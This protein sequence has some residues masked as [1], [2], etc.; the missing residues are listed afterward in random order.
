MG[1]EVVPAPD[2]F[3]FS[4]SYTLYNS[5]PFTHTGV[6]GTYSVNE[7]LDVYAGWT[8]GWDTGFNNL[9]QGN[10]F[11]GG[12]AWSITDNISFAYVNTIGNF[13]VRSAGNNGYGHSCV[14]DVSLGEKWNYVFQSDLLSIQA[15]GEDNIGINQ[16]LFYDYSDRCDLGCRFEWWSA[17]PETNFDYGGQS[18]APVDQTSYYEVTAGVNLKLTANCRLRPEFRYDWSP[19]LDYTQSIWAID[20]VTT[21]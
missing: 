13:G 10:N 5:E 1:Y 9:D 21:W 20:W 2:N 7:K 12:F 8:L 18:A 6:L 11:L 19:T 17:G 4:H 16:Y 15:T 14:F 3:F